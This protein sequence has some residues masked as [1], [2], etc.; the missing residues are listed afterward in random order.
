LANSRV[1]TPLCVFGMR[2]LTK[3]F[4]T[5]AVMDSSA[6]HPLHVPG[7]TLK[8]PAMPLGE[9]LATGARD[10]LGRETA[11]NGGASHAAT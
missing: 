6:A 5:R 11:G 9:A 3:S 4:A 7:R 2:T 8:G 1:K 10:G